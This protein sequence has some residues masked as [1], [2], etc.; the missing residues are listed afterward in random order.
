[1]VH[2]V[3]KVKKSLREQSGEAL[4]LVLHTAW[5]QNNLIGIWVKISAVPVSLKKKKII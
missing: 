1:M 3:A 2:L 4:H 5:I